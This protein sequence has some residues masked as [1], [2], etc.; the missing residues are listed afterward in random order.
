MIPCNVESLSKEWKKQVLF[1]SVDKIV[2][3]YT[4]IALQSKKHPKSPSSADNVQKYAKEF[5]SLALLYEEFEDAIREGDSVRV[6]RCWKFLL[7]V[8][9]VANG[10][11]YSIEA[12][13]LLSQYHLFLSPRL[14][15]QLAWSQFV[16]THGW[17]GYNIPCDLHMEHI[18]RVCKAAVKL[19][20]ANLTPKAIVRVGR[21]IGPLMNAT[22]QFDKECGID[23]THGTHSKASVKKDLQLVVKELSEKSKVF[24]HSPGR[25]HDSFKS[26]KGSILEKLEKD[27]LMKWME[28]TIKRIYS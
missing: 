27:E 13:V 16:N 7:L 25:R 4:N 9:K 26:L 21:C 12:L 18:N 20:G 17:P 8:F 2:S 19:L 11:N 1:E 22:H 15:Q 28:H 24:M 23:P 5:I 14:A 3:R 10:M 6:L